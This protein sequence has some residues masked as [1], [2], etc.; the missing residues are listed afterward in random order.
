MKRKILYPLI[1]LLIFFSGCSTAP[2]INPAEI[3]SAVATLPES[4]RSDVRKS[5]EAAGRNA[6]ELI[7]A[8]YG[9]DG[10]EK[11]GM[12]FLLANMPESDLKTLRG[13]FL[14][15][16]VKLAYQVRNEVPWSK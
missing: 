9:V 1:F 7:S 10:G 16:N 3:T 5:L 14:I 8:I 4:Y 6:D 12:A 13:E 15:Q 2:R 11:T